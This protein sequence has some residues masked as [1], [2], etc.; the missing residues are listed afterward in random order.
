VPRL[1]IAMSKTPRLKRSNR[2][3]RGGPKYIA[4]LHDVALLASTA[5]A[6]ELYV[7]G[8]RQ[9]SMSCLLPKLNAVSV[10]A[11]NDEAYLAYIC[12]I[13][14]CYFLHLTKCGLGLAKYRLFNQFLRLADMIGFG[15]YRVILFKLVSQSLGRTF[16]VLPSPF[17]GRKRYGRQHCDTV[18]CLGGGYE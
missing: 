17:D 7:V 5:P 9:P 13:A 4:A 14:T 12:L 3:C 16:G 10:R 18:P 8:T 1:K 11:P 15:Q 2:L 6:K